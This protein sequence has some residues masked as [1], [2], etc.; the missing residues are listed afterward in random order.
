MDLLELE[1]ELARVRSALDGWADRKQLS[2][3]DAR[4]SHVEFMRDQHGAWQ[5]GR[6]W[7]R[8]Q[9]AGLWL[10]QGAGT[11]E[12][13]EHAQSNAR[14]PVTHSHVRTLILCSPLHS[15]AAKMQ[16]MRT[17]QGQMET[18]AQLVKQRVCV[19]VY[20]CVCVCVCV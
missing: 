16:G 11:R 12:K 9:C 13:A 2:A 1:H 19:H 4:D 18:A 10:S 5:A 15:P 14:F 3:E 20:M 6:G 7:L 17:K 8:V